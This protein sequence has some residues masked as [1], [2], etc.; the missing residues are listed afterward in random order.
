MAANHPTIPPFPADID[1]RDFGHY[2]SGL[3]DGEGC[4]CASVRGYKGG[5]PYTSRI[6]RFTIKLR[7]DDC[8]ILELIQ[9]FWQCGPIV[10]RVEG[11]CRLD[12]TNAQTALDIRRIGDL[13]RVVIPHFEAFPLRAKKRADFDV[14]KQAVAL[15]ATVHRRPRHGPGNG[16]TYPKWTPAEGERFASLVQALRDVRRF[17]SGGIPAPIIPDPA[18]PQADQRLFW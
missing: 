4:F 8:P 15:C 14:W 10:H 7:A 18:P 17:E 3:V 16:G 2:L 9:Q 5:L 6:V 13:S 11:T 1:R 12:G